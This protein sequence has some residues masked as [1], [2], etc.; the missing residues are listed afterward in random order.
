MFRS[1][2]PL[3]LPKG[4]LEASHPGQGPKS[5][6]GGG[7]T[8][9]K[10]ICSGTLSMPRVGQDRPHAGTGSAARAKTEDKSQP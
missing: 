3:V 10:M 9:A 4:R 6:V 1:R 7:N 8:G 5:A 2:G